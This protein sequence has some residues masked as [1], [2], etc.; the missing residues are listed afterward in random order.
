VKILIRGD[1]RYG[2]IEA[3]Q[4]CDRLRVGYIFGL[5]GNCVVL[6]KV[7]ELAEDVA[8]RRLDA[9]GSKV[10]RHGEIDYAAK[11]WPAR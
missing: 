1:S 3:I 2:R 10:R 4:V 11:S 6:R 9:G 7:D 8:M 5:A